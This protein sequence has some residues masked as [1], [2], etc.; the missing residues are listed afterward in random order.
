VTPK[1]EETCF[2]TDKRL[3]LQQSVTRRRIIEGKDILFFAVVYSDHKERGGCKERTE[4]KKV[5]DGD[6]G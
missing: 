6:G 3:S 5:K 2:V 4:V 1:N